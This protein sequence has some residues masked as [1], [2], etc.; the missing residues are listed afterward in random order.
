[1]TRT[2][3]AVWGFTI[4]AFAVLALECVARLLD[5]QLGNPL[6]QFDVPVYDEK[7]YLAFYD[8]LPSLPAQ[9]GP[10]SSFDRA[11][12]RARSRVAEGGTFHIA[13]FGGSAAWGF[14]LPPRSAFSFPLQRLLDEADGGIE[15]RVRNEAEPGESSND[16]LRRLRASLEKGVD[17]AIVYLGNN[18]LHRWFY[19]NIYRARMP[20]PRRAQIALRRSHLYRWALLGVTVARGPSDFF[21]PGAYAR[22]R[23]YDMDYCDQ[24]PYVDSDR[25]DPRWWPRIKAWHIERLR[26]NLRAMAA[27]TQRRDTVLVLCAAPVNLKVCPCAKERQPETVSPLSPEGRARYMHCLREGDRL[28]TRWQ[29][30]E[31]AREYEEAA[32]IDPLA[33]RPR[34]RLAQCHE[35]LGRTDDARRE[36]MASR[37]N[38]IGYL[39][40]IRSVNE[41]TL[42]VAR[43]TGAVGV[44]LMEVFLRESQLRGGGLASELM[45]DPCHPTIEGH[46]LIAR[47]LY[48]RMVEL[49]LVP[50]QR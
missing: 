44:D 49:G 43:A 39:G 18:E 17:V 19:P 28:R 33:T 31:A 46:E 10:G 48:A 2:R 1:M 47:V 15:C 26:Q 29:F 20:L 4:A 34:Y 27:E 45:L 3:K 9:H 40:A 38:M 5:R 12:I 37:G 42:K 36:Y 50:R 25:F 11:L 35:A 14:S 41:T 7:A 32:R 24:H 13:A 6:A 21:R 23:W 16:V 8:R 30:A 22:N